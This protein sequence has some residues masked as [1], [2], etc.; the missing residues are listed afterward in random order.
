M[1]QSF[2]KKI[3]CIG[4]GYVGGP[5]MAV[6]ADKCPRYKVTVVD[7]D[8]GK[9]A[10]WNSD[11]L[12]VYEPGL[13]DVVQRARGKNLFFSTDVPAAIAEADI[14]FVSV[15]TPTKTTGVGAGMAADLRYWENTARQIRQCADTPKIVVEKSTVPVKTAEAMAQILSTE[16]SGNR[17]EVLSNPE[18]LAEGTAVADL[19]NPDRVVI[20][21]RQTPEGLA[22]RDALVEVYANWVPGEKILVS[23]IWSSEMAK[24]AANAFLAQRVSSINTIA[25]ICESSGA[26]VQEVSRAVGMDRRIGPKFLN[27]G[28]G[29]GGSCFKKDILSL[30]YLCRDAG[31][32]AEADYW[33]SVVRINEHQKERFVRRM[34]DAMF[35]SMADKRIAL[36]GFAFKP[37]T[38]DIRDAP[39]ITIARRLLDE[40]AVL[41][42]TDPRALDGARSVFGNA[43][44]RVAYVDDPY[45]A[46]KKSHA[47]AVLT[48]WQVYRDLDYTAIY[49]AMEKP[50]FFFDGR[51][52]ADHAALFDMGFNVYPVGM[53]AMTHF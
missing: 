9:I 46:A 19:E 40:G 11:T 42:I 16:N 39:A 47:I 24:L 31:A 37:D 1:A 14:I 13:L 52:V 53:P 17:F 5:T 49:A 41:A 21:S 22:A 28:V 25:N 33:E 12:P 32:D 38:G 20:G 10:A 8:A 15:N 35:H 43:D 3:L 2:E 48:E 4:A 6:I 36:F 50:A 30:A 27:A 26:N 51:N 18:F 7:I 23:N 45:Q 34:L 29:F 44:G